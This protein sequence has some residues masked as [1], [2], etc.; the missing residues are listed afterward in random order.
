MINRG[1]LFQRYMKYSK[2]ILEESIV[3][4]ITFFKFTLFLEIF[5]EDNLTVLTIFKDKT[6]LLTKSYK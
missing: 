3:H 2:E 6:L 5:N 4:T 1:L